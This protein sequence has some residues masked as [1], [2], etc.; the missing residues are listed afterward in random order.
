M[1]FASRRLVGWVT[2]WRIFS[3]VLKGATSDVT[4][5]NGTER[6]KYRRIGNVVAVSYYLEFGST[7]TVPVG[8]WRI[9]GPA[10]LR[11]HSDYDAGQAMGSVQCAESG[12]SIFHGAIRFVN[13]A[14]DEEMDFFVDTGQVTDILPFTWGTADRFSA[15][16]EY[17]TDFT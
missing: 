16:W 7:T 15:V 13:A 6:A 3:P 8:A 12:G 5:N 2:D 9:S 11:M 14:G 4:V 17:E 1:T 10:G